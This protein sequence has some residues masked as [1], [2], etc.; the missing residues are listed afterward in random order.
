MHE[1]TQVGPQLITVMY[2]EQFASSV[3]DLNLASLSGRLVLGGA[4][5]RLHSISTRA[6][7]F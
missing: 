2:V 3:T 7:R 5:V 1:Q 6:A 4:N